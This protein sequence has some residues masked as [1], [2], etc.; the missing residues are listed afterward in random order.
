MFSREVFRIRAFRDLW[1]GQTISQLGDSMYYVAFMFMAQELTGSIA[2]VGYVGAM[3]MLPYLFVGPYAGV[4]ADRIDRRRIMLLSDLCSA[5]VLLAFAAV[6]LAYHGKP[7]SAG[8]LAIPF[9][10]S[11]MRCFFMPAKSASVPN[12]VPKDLLTKANA[13]SNGTFNIISLMGLALSATVISQLYQLSPQW[14]F[15]SLLLLNALSFA[16]SAV[17]VSRLPALRPDREQ[18]EVKHP[19]DDFKSGLR[20][21]RGR[22][23]LKMFIVYLSAFRLGV[24]P[25]FVVYVA[26]NTQWF[27][28][29]PQTLMW[30]EFA[31]FAGMMVGTAIAAGLKVKRP[32]VWFSM[33]LALIGVFLSLMA[34]PNL[35][36]FIV[37]NL[38]CGLVVGAGDVPIMTYLQASV[39]DAFRGRV[40]S[41]KDMITVGIM[42]IGMVLGG[43]LLRLTGLVNAFLAMGA[44]MTVAGVAGLLDRRYRNVLMPEGVHGTATASQPAVGA[45]PHEAG[46]A[47]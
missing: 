40:N 25:F 36:L 23:D 22:H 45:E 47:A 31:F 16:G 12:L 30:L 19:L 18:A 8:L 24:A 14:F 46:S 2:M 29:K 28:G 3:E 41:A 34:I 44:L 10:L 38:I 11:T 9:A 1:L 26:A 43:T 20:Y 6:S 13:L 33:E 27:G 17:Y 35:P 37:V 5:G 39:E 32:T 4:V 15:A 42:P 21:I 7:P